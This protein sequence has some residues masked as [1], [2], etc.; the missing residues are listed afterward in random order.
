MCGIKDKT[1]KKRHDYPLSDLSNEILP[2]L[3][4]RTVDM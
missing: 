4:L 2:K 3:S 1:P